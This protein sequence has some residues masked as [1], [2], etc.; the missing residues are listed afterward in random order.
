[1]PN[2]ADSAC[3]AVLACLVLVASSVAAQDTY[4]TVTLAEVATTTRT[5][6]CTV[7]PVVYV[8]RQ[9]DGDIHVTLDDGRGRVVLEFMPQIPLTAP[10]KGQRIKACGVTRIDRGHRTAQFPAGWPE[11]HP[12]TS[13]AVI[14]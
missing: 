11:I 2:H 7:G 8:R 5:H 10:K 9:A 4:R 1:M 3:I 14:P 12:V 13:Y 6:V